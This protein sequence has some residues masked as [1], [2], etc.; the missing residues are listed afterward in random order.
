MG[1]G[2]VNLQGHQPLI[3]FRGAGD[4]ASGAAYRLARAGFPVAMCELPFPLAVRTT[5]S[6]S[7]AVRYAVVRIEGITARAVPLAEVE[8]IQQTV[9]N[10]EIAIIVDPEGE[11][12]QQLRPAVVVDARLAKQPLDTHP[13][14]APLVIA[15]GPGFVA[16][17]DC[18][19][20]VETHRSH[21]LGR[22]YWQGAAEPNTGVPAPISGFTVDRVLRAPTTGP[23]AAL[24]VIGCRVGQGDMLGHIGDVPF[25]AP[26][27]GVI[28]GL[29]DDDTHVQQGMKIG[30][31]DPRVRRIHCFTIS[32]KSL[33]IGGGV[34]EAVLTMPSI[35]QH[36]AWRQQA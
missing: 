23:M 15:L 6:F 7:S 32:D 8:T 5:V 9:A 24:K 17:K 25:Y 27:D 34:L 31:L 14:A 33:A 10:G 35:R 21:F 36:F 19:A 12:I 11:A 4:L 29:L 16:G 3:L 26:F 1:C 2:M 28:R 30:D 13:E 22:V 18:H 20:V